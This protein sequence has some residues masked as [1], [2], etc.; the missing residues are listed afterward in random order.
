MSSE[1]RSIYCLIFAVLAWSVSSASGQ[2]SKGGH[3]GYEVVFAINAGGEAHVDQHDT[4]FDRDPL[5]DRI[6]IASDFGKN[7]LTIGRIDYLPD[8]YLYQTERYHTATFGYDMPLSGDGDYLLQLMFS[9]VY[10]KA[11]GMKVFDVVLNQQH[12]V[13]QALDI[14]QKVRKRENF[15]FSRL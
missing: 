9:E 8:E 15:S 13:V 12:T 11:P 3:L 10:F 14:F 5:M 7:L 2:T 1:I 4:E 6:G